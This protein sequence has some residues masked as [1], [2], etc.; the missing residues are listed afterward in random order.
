MHNYITHLRINMHTQPHTK[1]TCTHMAWYIPSLHTFLYLYICIYQIPWPPQDVVRLHTISLK[2]V[3]KIDGK[4]SP[5]AAT[6]AIQTHDSGVLTRL[7]DHT[8]DGSLCLWIMNK[9]PFY[10]VISTVEPL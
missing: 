2:D 5:L 9:T 1:H 4:D 8:I 6:S 10:M 3:R 7:R